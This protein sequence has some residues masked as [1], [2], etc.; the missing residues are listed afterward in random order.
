MGL[1]LASSRIARGR[2]DAHLRRIGGEDIRQR[3]SDGDLE[4]VLLLPSVSQEKEI[5]RRSRSRNRSCGEGGKDIS[6]E[7]TTKVRRGTLVMKLG[8]DSGLTVSA[9]SATAESRVGVVISHPGTGD[10]VCVGRPDEGV[11]CTVIHRCE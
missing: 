6:V 4:T 5:R 2:R 10:P 7:V 1:C 8:I 3:A 11:Q 9:E